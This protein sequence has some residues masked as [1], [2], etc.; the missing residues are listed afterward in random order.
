MLKFLIHIGTCGTKIRLWLLLFDSWHWHLK[1]ILLWR[2]STLCVVDLFCGICIHWFLKLERLF[3]NLSIGNEWVLLWWFYWN[4][5]FLWVVKVWRRNIAILIWLNIL[6][7][8]WFHLTRPVVLVW[9]N[10][11]LIIISKGLSWGGIWIYRSHFRLVII[12]L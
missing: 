3:F 4:N 10:C 8:N 12:I 7:I 1:H 5:F 9:S 11:W 6:E 2:I